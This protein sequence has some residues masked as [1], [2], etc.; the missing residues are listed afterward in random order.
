MIPLE[1]LTSCFQGLIPSW[2]CTC[3][4]DGIPN[5]AI[6]SHVDYVDPKH[7]ALSFQFFNKSKRN[8]MENPKA[9]VR[10]YDPDTFQV[11]ALRLRFERTE[12][13]G[14]LFESMRLRIEAIA[15]HS[16][17]KG[18]FRLLGADVYEV[19]SVA[20]L[21]HEV[22][23]PAD[24]TVAAARP[25]TP[26]VLFTMRAL[27]ELSDR[28]HRAATL[29]C[30]LES[31]LEGLESLFGFRNSMILLASE[32]P[33]RVET[34]ASRGY[35][36]GGV[37]SEVGFGEGIIGMVAEARKPIRIAGMLRYMLYATATSR[38]AS[39]RGL[40]VD[41]RRIPLPGLPNPDSQLGIPLLVRDELV[42]VLCIESDAPYRFHEEDRAYLEVLGG[43]LAIAIQNALLHERNEEGVV[44]VDPA[45]KTA[46]AVA[47]APLAAPTP[48]E[49]GDAVARA[50]RPR[51]AVE[52]FTADECI[53]V[54]GEYLVR[55]LPAKL[56]R[57]FLRERAA[58]GPTEFTN[59][60]LRLD[61]TLGLPEFKDNLESRLILLRRRLEERCPEI[62]LVQSGRGRFLLELG[63][64][65]ELSERD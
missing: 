20:R 31:I 50:L 63:A 24:G 9:L 10:L 18:V 37:G 43:Y 15:T 38:A 17:A 13:E 45:A 64:E 28:I 1:S 27:Q 60:R 6:L 41:E 65:V 21:D 30:L 35:P 33:D 39:E 48:K 42:G 34:I 12:T 22:G 55:G 56:L 3:S 47:G 5:V 25:S 46:G 23:L 61:R 29:D 52:Y 51:I 7:V 59:R 49:A 62:R 36:E 58:A 44:D 11:Y 19:L 4:K 53:L 32:R 54:D 14:P 8:V 26:D 16:G 57:K 40:A 2:L